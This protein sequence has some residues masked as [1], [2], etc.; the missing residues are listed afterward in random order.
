MVVIG[1]DYIILI[2][3]IIIYLLTSKHLSLP[4]SNIIYSI[5]GQIILKG[6]NSYIN[7]SNEKITTTTTKNTLYFFK[8]TVNSVTGTARS[9]HK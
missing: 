5:Q 8:N 6:Y 1:K 3:N 2:F 9:E 4:L 7:L